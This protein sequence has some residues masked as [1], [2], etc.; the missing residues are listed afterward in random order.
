MT[1]KDYKEHFSI[2][3]GKVYYKEFPATAEKF[4]ILVAPYTESSILGGIQKFD[5]ALFYARL[6]PDGKLIGQINF[7]DVIEAIE[8][9]GTIGDLEAA[10]N[11]N[12]D[13]LKAKVQKYYENRKDNV[14]SKED[15]PDLFNGEWN[16]FPLNEVPFQ[17][18][19][20][21][22]FFDKLESGLNLKTLKEFLTYC[23]EKL[24]FNEPELDEIDKQEILG[25]DKR[26]DYFARQE[27]RHNRRLVS[28]TVR[29]GRRRSEQT[30]AD[31]K[32]N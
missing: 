8:L 26:P 13:K 5:L 18:D 12:T 25:H 19:Y 7:I 20:F 3:Y 32:M 16:F 4:I 22:S 23:R 15:Y 1:Y 29:K 6:K 11:N 31:G 14:A 28:A 30:P 21:Q 24:S 27:L 2:K 10:I 9:N 17:R